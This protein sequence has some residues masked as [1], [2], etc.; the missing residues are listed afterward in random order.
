MSAEA[1]RSI[2][3]EVSKITRT[4]SYHRRNKL[5]GGRHL[6]NLCL[7]ELGIEGQTNIFLSK[8]MT[9]DRSTQQ[10][11]FLVLFFRTSITLLHRWLVRYMEQF[12]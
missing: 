12:S 7:I 9:E 10:D 1:K 3:T 2:S 11:I 5:E 8:N 6:L 4:Q